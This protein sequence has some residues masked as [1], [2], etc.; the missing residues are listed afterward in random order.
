MRRLLHQVMS[1]KGRL[2]TNL[3]HE[4]SLS[5]KLLK[6]GES[7]MNYERKT[8]KDALSEQVQRSVSSFYQ[9]S[10]VSRELPIQRAVNK[11]NVIKQALEG[12]LQYSYKTF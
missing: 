8:R 4:M 7:V 6:E 5:W 3:K 10:D 2:N 1:F 11:K 12:S 9:R